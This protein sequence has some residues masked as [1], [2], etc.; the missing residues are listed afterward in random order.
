M[1]IKKTE[2]EEIMKIEPGLKELMSEA[3]SYMEN[4]SG[5]YMKRSKFWNHSLKPR[6]KHLVG[7]MADKPEL[8]SCEAY[9]LAY[10]EFCKIL[11]I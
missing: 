1:T 4:S 8:N 9:D 11:K 6:F 10:M 5:G 3:V 2:L 7:F